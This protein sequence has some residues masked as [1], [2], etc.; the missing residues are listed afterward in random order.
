M[1]YKMAAATLIVERDLA[2][3]VIVTVSLCVAGAK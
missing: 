1:P 3:D 2:N